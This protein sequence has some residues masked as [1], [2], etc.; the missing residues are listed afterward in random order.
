MTARTPTKRSPKKAP[1]KPRQKRNGRPAPPRQMTLA[2]TNLRLDG[3]T[4]PRAKIDENVV[5]DY[6]EAYGKKEKLPPLTVFNDGTAYWLADGFHRVRGAKKVGRIKVQCE[7]YKG[8]QEDAR[9]YSYSANQTHGLRRS[10]EDKRK[11]V[12]AALKHPRGKKM[13]DRLIAD[14]CGVCNTFVGLLRRELSTVDSC[15]TETVGKDGKVRRRKPPKQR[16][17]KTPKSIPPIDDDIDANDGDEIHDDD[18]YGAANI[19]NDRGDDDHIDTTNG[20]EDPGNVTV[21]DPSDAPVVASGT[22][23]NFSADILTPDDDP[24][25]GDDDDIDRSNGVAIEQLQD[26]FDAY[27]VPQLKAASISVRKQFYAW[28]EGLI[29]SSA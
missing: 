17:T 3:D 4:Q 20:A 27:V 13:S 5:N 9:W 25:G 8:E 28:L 10:N 29:K 26:A 1:A 2:L 11:C 14:H 23:G 12:F 24:I 6:A 16:K 19:T 18:K 7:V 21:A 15:P 22:P